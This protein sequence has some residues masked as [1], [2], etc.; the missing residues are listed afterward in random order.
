MGI[1][2]VELWLSWSAKI[3]ATSLS[4]GWSRSRRTKLVA[5][6]LT[7]ILTVR[8]ESPHVADSHWS[9]PYKRDSTRVSSFLSTDAF[10][11]RLRYCRAWHS[12]SAC[13][14]DRR[15]QTI[16]RISSRRGDRYSQRQRDIEE[17]KKKKD[18]GP[19]S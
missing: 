17:G 3:K 2:K 13:N 1:R 5:R 9:C 7:V 4:F 14:S 15:Q 12:N 6:I 10:A 8:A 16:E 19:Q 11:L 18:K